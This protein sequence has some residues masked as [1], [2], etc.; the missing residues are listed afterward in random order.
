MSNS[1][2]AALPEIL[3]DAGYLTLM[4]GKWHLGLTKETSHGPEV[5]RKVLLYFLARVTIARLICSQRMS[6]TE[7]IQLTNTLPDQD[8]REPLHDRSAGPLLPPLYMENDQFIKV[9]DQ[10]LPRPVQWSNFLVKSAPLF[11]L[12]TVPSSPF[13]VGC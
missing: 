4:S 11:T 2:V 8:A 10:K 3:S 6:A 7:N 13:L 1:R 9:C 12:T 5:F